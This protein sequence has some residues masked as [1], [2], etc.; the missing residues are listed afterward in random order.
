MTESSTKIRFF[1]TLSKK[2]ED[3]QTIKSN[4]VSLYTCGP[5]VYDSSHIG[6][7]RSVIVWDCLVRYLRFRG[8]NVKW[9]RNITDIDDK[10]I[11]R[12]KDL[13]ISPE[14]LARQ[15]TYD[16]WRDMQSLH[17]TWPDY[18]P[19]ATENLIEMYQFIQGLIDRKHAYRTENGDVYFDVKSFKDYGQLK[20]LASSCESLA[21]VDH[22]DVKKNECDFALWKAC[23]QDDYGYE[24]P[25]SYGRPGWH[26]E[27]SAM[28]KRYF[29]ETI[30]IHG[31]GEDLVFPHHENEIAQSECLHNKKFVN[32][33]LHNAMIMVNGSKMSKSEGNY[34]TISE[35]LKKYCGN[36]IRF[37][38]LSAHYRQPVNYTEEALNAAQNG[39][40]RLFNSI[41]KD[42]SEQEIQNK[43]LNQEA[44]D[45]FN[46][47]MSEDLNTACALS[48]L[49]EL[50]KQINKGETH[51]EPTLRKLM[52]V[53]GFDLNVQK[54]SFSENSVESLF[55]FLIEI[56]N[57]AREQKNY[58]LSD[59]IRDEFEKAGYKLKD[60][61]TGTTLAAN[62]Q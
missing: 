45:K 53:L 27:C 32:Y 22:Q 23:P 55:D 40:H 48:V 15:Q 30:D 6:H 60:S 28:I 61:P 39:F 3:F 26:L 37:F 35:S 51:L 16:F 18:E 24:S 8:F 31:G 1:N 29:G 62:C 46:F 56:R 57:N 17:V 19:R 47:Y 4:E 54:E 44:I 58:A 25:F 52:Q 10:I 11:N 20:N 33:W 12:S 9:A 34:V 42:A 49:F 43:D 36:T 13:G 41:N 38:V 7:A 14:L 59:R 5:T 50:S 21:R 2:L